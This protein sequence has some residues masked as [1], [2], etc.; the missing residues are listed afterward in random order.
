MKILKVNKIYGM[1]K[2]T[3]IQCSDACSYFTVD[4]D[5]HTAF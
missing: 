5:C 1:K 2:V 4:V 3:F